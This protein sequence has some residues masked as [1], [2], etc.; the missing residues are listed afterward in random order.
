MSLASRDNMQFYGT[1]LME[2]QVPIFGV[3]DRLNTPCQVF[4]KYFRRII[5]GGALFLHEGE[6][7]QLVFGRC[8]DN[9]LMKHR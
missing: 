2:R 4:V 3:I 8:N 9:I 7:Y 6:D 1:F 5:G